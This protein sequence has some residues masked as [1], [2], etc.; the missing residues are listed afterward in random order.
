NQNKDRKIMIVTDILSPLLVLHSPAPII[1]Y[2]K[3]L[4]SQIKT[5]DAVLLAFVE[6]EMNTP[7]ALESIEQ[8]FDSEIEFRIY[9]NGLSLTPL[10]RIKKV[11]GLSALN[12]YFSFG[13]SQSRGMEITPYVRS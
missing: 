5:H 12:V 13:F 1:N 10:L 6:E 2:W 4:V 3:Q 11:L 8:L 9:E 7:S